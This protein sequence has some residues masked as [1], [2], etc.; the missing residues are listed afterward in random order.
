VASPLTEHQPNTNGPPS[1]LHTA[2]RTATI[3]ATG[4]ACIWAAWLMARMFRN[5]VDVPFVDQWWF[6]RFMRDTDNNGGLT[7]SSLWVPHNEHR[8]F[9]PRLLM[10]GLA[11][12]TGWNI[13]AETATVQIFLIARLVFVAGIV[14]TVARKT[15]HSVWLSL[16]IVTAVLCTRAQAENLLWGWQITL[17]LCALMTTVCCLLVCR[18]K[19]INFFFAAVC[20]LIAQFSF[21]SGLVLWPIGLVGLATQVN[22][23]R[24]QRILRS[25]VWISIGVAATILGNRNTFRLPPTHPL[26][27]G[28]VVHYSLM[29]LGGPFAGDPNT[30][31]VQDNATRW[32]IIGL[33]LFVAAVTSVLLTKQ[34]RIWLPI[35]LWGATAPATALVTAYGRTVMIDSLSQA[36]SSRY[37]TL[38][39]PMWAA[40]AIL[41]IASLLQLLR[42]R[43]PAA[44]RVTIACISCVG[45]WI[46]VDQAEYWEAWAGVTRVE[47]LRNRAILADP[48]LLSDANKRRLFLEP[49][50]I[51]E[52]RPFLVEKHY[53]VFRTQPIGGNK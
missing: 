2:A 12:L 42:G 40:S 7:L 15:K 17:T 25:A 31:R 28:R 30:E 23:S 20:A 10:F 33:V 14:L 35:I 37:V 50:W 24:R 52:L 45:S 5:T 11:K 4:T 26:T 8:V 51:D 47:L 32:G 6:V 27:V 1:G 44:A 49:E 36:L 9:F 19:R 29:F 38:S 22:L 13:R 39:A 21:A 48:A 34:F 3:I 46:I 16:P 53:T 18:E 41:L 43:V